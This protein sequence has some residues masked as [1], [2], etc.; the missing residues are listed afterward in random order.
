[1]VAGRSKKLDM[2]HLNISQYILNNRLIEHIH[3]VMYKTRC[4]A[5]VS[6]RKDTVPHVEGAVYFTFLYLQY[7]LL[8]SHRVSFYIFHQT[9]VGRVR[10]NP[11]NLCIYTTLKFL[12]SS[13]VF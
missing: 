7:K 3:W 2:Q 4:A 9:E 1:M 6:N 13:Y 10:I 12:T 8:V 11:V 5:T